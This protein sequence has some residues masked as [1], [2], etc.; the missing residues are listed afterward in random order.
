ML[1]PSAASAA[2]AADPTYVAERGYSLSLPGGWERQDAPDGAAFAA[3]SADGY[4]E[5]TLWVERQPG[6]SFDAFVEKSTASL[7]ELATAVA[8]T[9]RVGGPTLESQIAELSAD[10]TL[11]GGA[12]APYRVTLR[13]AG[14]YRYYLATS[15]QPG[16]PANLL[17]DAE[18]L[19][20]SFRPGR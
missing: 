9:D 2:S 8:V 3:V 13:A 17:G 5:T 14:P 15:V 19:S 7:D 11:D 12:V 20:G 16:G 10:V 6:M 1:A 4:A 18:L